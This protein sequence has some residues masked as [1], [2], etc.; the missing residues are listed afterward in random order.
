MTIGDI[1][2]NSRGRGTTQKN[3]HRNKNTMYIQK[4]ILKRHL[5]INFIKMQYY[6]NNFK[7]TNKLSYN[8]CAK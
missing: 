4:Y 7:K 1:F 6:L 5:K 8:S 3:S 2:A